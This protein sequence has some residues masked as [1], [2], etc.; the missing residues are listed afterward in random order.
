MVFLALFQ[1][2][3]IITPHFR[4][5]KRWQTRQFYGVPKYF[6]FMNADI[7]KKFF[8]FDVESIGIHGE[9]FAVGFVVVDTEGNRL[10]SGLFSCPSGCARGS[11]DGHAWVGENC[12]PLLVT[13]DS[14]WMVRAAFWKVWLGWKCS[15]V[16]MVAD[17][18]WPVEARFLAQCVDDRFIEREFAGP[19]PLHD[20]ASVFLALGQDPTKI[21]D[22]LPEE[23][24][25]HNPLCD[26][27]QSARLLL[28]AIGK[29]RIPT[30]N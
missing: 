3:S 4:G 25:S 13:H 20:L 18:A 15:D 9:G 17:C 2:C 24:P 23:L 8:V 27:K 16:V 12:P 1:E 29:P 6:N 21:M 5:R 11:A 26:A 10:D 7:A 28:S 22:R 30:P 14:P 19:Y